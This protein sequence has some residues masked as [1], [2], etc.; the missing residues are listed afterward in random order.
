M[1][2]HEDGVSQVLIERLSEKILP[3]LLKMKEKVDG[4]EL[5]SEGDIEIMNRL[6]QR[7]Q[8]RKNTQ[9]IESHEQYKP[10][11]A[12]IINLYEQIIEVGLLNEKRAGDKG[13]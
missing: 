6:I 3:V 10:L 12:K 8:A 4:G 1:D 11:I 5:L 13:P 7:A 9:F 2:N